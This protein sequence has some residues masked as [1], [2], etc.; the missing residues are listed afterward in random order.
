MPLAADSMPALRPCDATDP[1][2]P[3]SGGTCDA[4][5]DCAQCVAT[6][7][8]NVDEYTP[9]APV[10]LA[11]PVACAA[12]FV[13]LP[14][15]TSSAPQC[16][17]PAC[18][19]Q[20]D[21]MGNDSIDEPNQHANDAS[22]L[23]ANCGKSEDFVPAMDSRRACGTAPAASFQN[24]A[25]PAHSP[26]GTMSQ[27]DG[28]AAV[29]RRSGEIAGCTGDR[30]SDTQS[31]AVPQ[32][33]EEDA[34]FASSTVTM[35]DKSNRTLATLRIS[36]AVTRDFLQPEERAAIAATRDRS[37]PLENATSPQRGKPVSP[38]VD[39]FE[40][41]TTGH[42]T[43]D[44]QTIE[45]QQLAADLTV[46]LGR[47][48]RCHESLSG[49]IS[50]RVTDTS[51]TRALER[52]VGPF[53]YAIVN[54][55]GCSVIGTPEALRYEARRLQDLHSWE[56]AQVTETVQVRREAMEEF[57]ESAE[58]LPPVQ[59]ATELAPIALEDN[60]ETESVPATSSQPYEISIGNKAKSLI[61]Q[62]DLETTTELLQEAVA[63]HPD[64]AILFRMLAEVYLHRGMYI[65]AR[66]AAQQSLALNRNNPMTNQVY[67]EVLKKMGETARATII[68]N[69]PN[70]SAAGHGCKPQDAAGITTR[71]LLPTRHFTVNSTRIGHCG[72]VVPNCFP[73]HLRDS[74]NH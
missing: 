37:Q 29:D 31:T 13:A 5:P 30:S 36:S 50:A 35:R 46:R 16:S 12:P 60:T 55:D 47:P 65:Q 33:P 68:W 64:S 6:C 54:L 43:I 10:A 44:A 7:Q 39:V 74:R 34:R 25:G 8:V 4:K 9:I 26:H 20:C 40:D 62:G 49:T 71:V 23:S 15:M 48:I 66:A 38:H 24:G 18:G 52:L 67:G 1:P 51:L 72:T 70:S 69:K 45:I 11:A 28:Q 14:S 56:E 19:Q 41:P 17:L 22:P 2:H 61:A 57:A 42:L 32:I 21:R 58:R 53:G 73:R 3:I 63:R 27:A 59:P